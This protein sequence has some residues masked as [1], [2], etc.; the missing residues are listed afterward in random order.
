MPKRSNKFQKLIHLMQH[1]LASDAEVTESALL[2]D[3]QTGS[4]VEVDV[5]I[6]AEIGGTVISVGIECRDRKRRETVEWVREVKGKHEHLP[7][8]KSVLVSS[9]GFTN[10][11]K[12]KAAALGIDILTI[13]EAENTEWNIYLE[14]LKE[15][16]FA[17]FSVSLIETKVVFENPSE[18]DPSKFGDES[19]L[20]DEDSGYRGTV[21]EYSTLL[22]RSEGAVKVTTEKWF[23]QQEK[24]KDFQPTINYTPGGLIH[25]V[26]SDGSAHVVKSIHFKV[27]IYVNEAPITMKPSS[28]RNSNFAIGEVEDVFSGDPDR[29][30]LIVSKEENG[31]LGS[32]VILTPEG[33]VRNTIKNED[34]SKKNT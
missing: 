15:L 12:R 17:G 18:V 7:I 8:N 24:P 11:A 9:S 14:S 29:M 13:D 21:N 6:Q 3:S 20:I 1:V 32:G 26:D 16:K 27:S 28:L 30:F 4:K 23:E 5:L 25:I 19:I 33:D 2:E 10:E 22:I 34:K 31:E